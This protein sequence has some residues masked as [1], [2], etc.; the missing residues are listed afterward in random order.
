[1][2]EYLITDD[3]DDG[4][5]TAGAWVSNDTSNVAGPH[6]SAPWHSGLRFQSLAIPQGA[7]IVSATLDLYIYQL[8]KEP[9]L[10]VYGVDEDNAAAFA[11]GN[12]PSSKTKTAASDTYD[13]TGEGQAFD[14]AT[15]NAYRQWD[16]TA[17]V[18]E[19]VDRVGWVSGN[20]M[21][22]L[23]TGDVG[24]ERRAWIQ[25]YNFGAGTQP[26]LN[27]TLSALPSI[28]NV[29]TD[30]IIS[31]DQTSVVITGTNLAGI[32]EVRLKYSGVTE[33]I[34]PSA[35][36]ATTVTFDVA[37]GDI[38]FG[39]V[40]L[41]IFDGT[42]TDTQAITIVEP[43]LND[44]VVLL[45]PG[46][47]ATTIFNGATHTP[48]STN[49]VEYTEAADVTI[50][51]NA[52]FSVVNGSVITSFDVR[53]WRSD[54]ET[55]GAWITITLGGAGN[56][57]PVV[58]AP[59]DIQI[60]YAYGTGGVSKANS[61]LVAWLNSATAN[62]AEQGA[63]VVIGDVSAYPDPMVAGAYDIDFD[64]EADD[65]GL[66]G[67]D[68]ATLTIVE[69]FAP[70][71]APVVTAPADIQIEF[72]FGSGGLAKSDSALVAWLASALVVDDTDVGLTAPGDIS[73]LADPIPASS[74]VV[75]FLS[76]A[77]AG[78]LTGSDTAT[79]TI[80]QGAPPNQAPIVSAPASI[81]IQFPNGSGGLPKN[82]AELLAWIALATV[83][84]DT[85]VGLT[86]SANLSALADPIPAGAH[87]I[88]FTSSLD[89]GALSGNDTSLLT[90]QE[91]PPLPQ[92]SSPPKGR[93]ISVSS[94]QTLF[95]KRSDEVLDF[96]ISLD[97]LI[98]DD[99]YL[100]SRVVTVTGSLVVDSDGILLT[101]VIDSEG[102]THRA[103]S[104]VY[105]WLSG[106]VNGII[107]T[108]EVTAVTNDGRTR[109]CLFDVYVN[110]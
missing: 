67:S 23:A 33:V 20:S 42:N 7:T 79:L 4:N 88:T 110:K 70:N 80:V 60:Q 12:L 49:Q 1:M 69:I 10:Y 3:A 29:D 100:L 74:T 46:I 78:S 90:I 71:T 14:W 63:L 24:T 62:D 28:A 106:G 77:D 64:S 6:T 96:W 91:A 94:P 97:G 85:D 99:D 53:E 8:H 43:T 55:W 82:N 92:Q 36:D 95:E 81:V 68:T 98:D 18:Q 51:S 48:L 89:A 17:I 83:S 40:T 30:N 32:T 107:N 87:V 2:T 13:F 27:I 11:N 19:I 102:I 5:E 73:A 50:Q 26:K 37:Q 59:A 108:V 25:D 9:L 35:T 103:N 52:T 16:V 86:V 22:F 65:F 101:S 45:N 104:V 72:A 75:T 44:Y 76:G 31:S 61:T 84:D 38:P 109:V 39:A 66:I 57:A 34:I 47:D 15:I 105:V 58:T 41:E 54:L 21:S 93:V 56:T